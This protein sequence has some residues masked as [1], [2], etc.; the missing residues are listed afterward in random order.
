MELALIIFP[1]LALLCAPA[2]WLVFSKPH[3]VPP[4]PKKTTEH[5]NISI[6]IPARN[7]EL[8]IR[9][10]LTSINAQQIKPLEII[11][12]N[13]GST[14]QTAQ[15][16]RELGATVIDA[17]P[18]P[19]DWKGK[20]WACHQGAQT[21]KGE[22]FLFL[23]ADT[24]LEAGALKNLLNL[25]DT[26]HK[27]YSIC[28]YHR[29]QR[30]YEELSS[31]FNVMML[32]GSSAFGRKDNHASAL[33]GQCMLIS[34]THYEQAGGH[35][36][37]KNQI[38]ENFHLANQL[39]QLGIQRQ[40]YIGKGTVSMRM[41]PGGFKE[42]WASWQKGF[43]GGAAHTAPSALLWSSIWISSL[44]FVLVSLGLLATPY[45]SQTYLTLTSTAYIFSS[46]QCFCAF[47]HAGSFSILN[48]LFFPITLLFYQVLFFTSIL[49]R[50]LGKQTQW[51]GRA[52][53]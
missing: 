46:I 34:R 49:N 17:A 7:E 52:V 48:A 40:C 9:N 44:M 21:A 26:Q 13:D 36:T 12:V 38:L 30:P 16:A 3:T 11:V 51:K 32:T 19:D 43:S 14:D 1:C 8:N 53:S 47:R 28:P 18:L 39:D 15:I 24:Q 22:W 2:L 41:F 45:T 33:F 29:I 5:C 4:S 6:I 42:L 10:L 31:F 25:T 35:T 37:V 23:D 50:K 27:V 20:P